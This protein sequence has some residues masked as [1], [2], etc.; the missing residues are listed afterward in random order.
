MAGLP[1][2]PSS[3]PSPTS[4]GTADILPRERAK[5]SFDLT[6]L[7]QALWGKNADRPP[8]NTEFKNLFAGAPFNDDDMD[9]FRSYEDLW[10]V[11]MKRTTEAIKIIRENPRLMAAH[12]VQRRVNMQD[13]FSTGSL[14]IHFS[15]FLTF[16]RTQG[17]EEQKEQWLAPAERAQFFGAYAQT[18]LGHGS[19]L[20]GLETTA[21]Y[22]KVTDEFVIHSPTLTSL[23]WWPTGMYC[24]T[25]GAVMANLII[26][27]KNLG[28]H[29][30]MVQF[31]DDEG[32]CMPGVEIGEIGPKINGRITNIGYARF[33]HVRIPRFN[34]FA[35]ASQVTREG[36]YITAPPKLS[37]FKYIS[38][39]EIRRDFV[40]ISF[41]SL[42]RAATIAVRYSC[43]RHQ[44]YKDNEAVQDGENAVL[45]YKMQQYRVFK[46]LSLSYMFLWNG[47]YVGEYLHRVQ[48]AI[49]KGDDKAADELPMLH[50]TLCGFKVF[51]TINSHANIEECRKACGGQGFLKSSGIADMPAQMAEPVTAEG[52]QVILSQQL[53]RFLVKEIRRVRHGATPS[54]VFAYLG[55]EAMKPLRLESYRRCIPE[56]LSLMRHRAALFARKLEASFTA[57]ERPGRTFEAI[58]NDCAV[59]AWKAAEC[60]TFY[61]FMANNDSALQNYVKDPI[62][63]TLLDRLLELTA[64]Q[65]IRE[66]GGDFIDVLDGHQLDLILERIN[67]ILTEVRPDAVALTDAF[68]WTDI[69]LNSTLGR[70]DGSVYEAIYEEAKKSPLNKSERM[71]GWEDFSQI[72]DLNILRKGMSTQR[73]GDDASLRE[74]AGA[75][76]AGSSSNVSVAAAAAKL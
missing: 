46:A 55:D 3:T 66:N 28:F 71:L 76:G 70:E 31:R 1:T 32:R 36:Q 72:L 37:K 63:K 57:A 29:G 69:Q 61:A 49:M 44:G 48:E 20:R 58:L 64:L 5:A 14:G 2:Q 11:T 23:K 21:T 51:A 45:D 27:G 73:A 25:H 33:T 50:A 59:L 34:M 53:S 68:G 24:C 7:R 47:R 67:E 56:L 17:N 8:A 26:D 30:F 9:T 41:A 6:S 74:A 19:N 65:H 62:V 12:K 42:S 10:R 52:E 22:D 60:H 75:H 16:I 18:E 38:M 4:G 35:R 39:M 15:M 54:G 13:L 40:N 43:I